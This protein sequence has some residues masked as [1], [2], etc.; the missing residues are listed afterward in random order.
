MGINNYCYVDQ[1]YLTYSGVI[2]D[3]GCL[4]WDWSAQFANIKRV[5]GID[6]TENECPPWATFIKKAV[7]ISNGKANMAI[8]GGICNS[9]VFQSSENSIV[10]CISLSSIISEYS[11]ISILKMNIEGSEYPLLMSVQHPVADQLIVSFHDNTWLAGSHFTNKTTE[12][13]IKYL[14]NWYDPIDIFPEFKWV[15]FLKRND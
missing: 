6:P 3:I 13:I 12:T 15:L 5:I 11:P 2:I 9:L 7:S 10:D 8:I 4:Y 14:E 1:R